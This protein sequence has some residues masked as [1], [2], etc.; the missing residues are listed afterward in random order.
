MDTTA[1]R[2]HL[3]QLQNTSTLSNKSRHM[4]RIIRAKSR[5]NVPPKK[6]YPFAKPNNVTSQWIAFY[7]V[8]TLKFS[9]PHNVENLHNTASPKQYNLTTIF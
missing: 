1:T 6:I 4:D 3:I 2:E 8:T 7:I 9:T 5:Q